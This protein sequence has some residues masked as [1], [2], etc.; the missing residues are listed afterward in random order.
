MFGSGS[1]VYA[2][3]WWLEI[4][5]ESGWK[6]AC[7]FFAR[8][9]SL[10][11]AR[12]TRARFASGAEGD[13]AGQRLLGE[14]VGA[15]LERRGPGRG[16][17]QQERAGAPGLAVAAGGQAERLD[18]LRG[19]S[20]APARRRRGRAAGVPS[21]MISAVLGP[22]RPGSSVSI[23][24]SV[25]PC[26]CTVTGRAAAAAARMRG[27]GVR[28]KPEASVSTARPRAISAVTLRRNPRAEPPAARRG[29]RRARLTAASVSIAAT[30]M[31][32]RARRRP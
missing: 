17:R 19:Q 3:S 11:S 26:R 29:V 30:A 1:K 5:L 15:D 21:G 28:R 31:S 14:V 2:A 12:G 8:A 10:T 18:A 27:G 7:H 24:I 4:Q 23:A 9:Q 6:V 32:F 20:Q 22:G 25:A 16:D 13:L